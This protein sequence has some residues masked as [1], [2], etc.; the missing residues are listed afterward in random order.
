MLTAINCT[1]PGINKFI[2]NSD[3]NECIDQNSARD[4]FLNFLSIKYNFFDNITLHGC[5]L[6]CT[7]VSFDYEAFQVHRNSRIE[8][9]EEPEL[10]DGVFFFQFSYNS[11][12]VEERV[13]TLAYDL[14]DFF[15]S[16]GGN[17]GLFLGFS[18]LSLLLSVMEFVRELLRK[19]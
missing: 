16:V 18:C 13:V 8:T 15:A 10:P 4:T 5:P 7:T 12:Q 19:L 14:A 3:L 17:L 2:R 9:A 1:I 11:L 6:P